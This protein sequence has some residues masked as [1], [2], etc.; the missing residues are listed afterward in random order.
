M[1][2]A[3][4]VLCFAFRLA[5]LSFASLCV[6][7]MLCAA[8]RCPNCAFFGASGF[9]QF[10][11]RFGLFCFISFCVVLF[12]GMTRFAL[13]CFALFLVVGRC[14]ALIW[15]GERAREAPLEHSWEGLWKFRAHDS[16]TQLTIAL[17]HSKNS[18]YIRR[19]T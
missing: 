10:V 12:L 16:P 13:F 14:F 4:P 5:L 19:M 2:R 9:T 17:R 1:H 7:C 3:K 15:G 6:A 18:Y 11:R 8:R